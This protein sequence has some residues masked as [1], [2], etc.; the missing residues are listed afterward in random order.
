MS[1]QVWQVVKR[2][3]ESRQLARTWYATLDEAQAAHLMDSK[4][5]APF[6]HTI[7]NNAAGTYTVG[8]YKVY[9]DTKGNTQVRSISI[10]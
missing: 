4:T 6:K 7:N 9:V 2:D 3:E 1:I 5:M 8:D 10:V